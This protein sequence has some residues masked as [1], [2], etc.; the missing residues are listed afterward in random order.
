LDIGEGCGTKAAT[1][2]VKVAF[3]DSVDETAAYA[4]CFGEIAKGRDETHGAIWGQREWL[5]LDTS[6]VG[7]QVHR[8][9]LNIDLNSMKQISLLLKG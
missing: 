9:R 8:R 7:A 2:D 1:C 6:E 3:A 4:R 5:D